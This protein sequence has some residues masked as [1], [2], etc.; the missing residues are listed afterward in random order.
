MLSLDALYP[1]FGQADSEKWGLVQQRI[2]QSSDE[3]FQPVGH[4]ADLRQHPVSLAVI[5]Q[6]GEAGASGTTGSAIR[7]HFRAP[8]FGWPQDAIDAALMGLLRDGV[9]IG[10]KNGV[11]VQFREVDLSAIP[12]ITFIAEAMP[13]APAERVKLRG[14]LNT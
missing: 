3:P 10:R 6:V 4:P 11:P 5:S 1:R 2:K 7:K 12:Q 9:F 14:I 13:V 8:P